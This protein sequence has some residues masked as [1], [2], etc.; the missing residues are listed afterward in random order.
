ME[1]TTKTTPFSASLFKILGTLEMLALAAVIVA[2]A[3]KYLQLPGGDEILMIGM[4]VLAMT[5]FLMAYKPPVP[6]NS[7]QERRGITHL[8]VDTILPK[9]TWTGCTIAVIGSLF[10]ILH[11]QGAG[12]MLM[13]GTSVLIVCILLSV[14]FIATGSDQTSGLM[15]ILY[16]A[17]PLCIFGIYVYMNLPPK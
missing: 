7:Q 13:V 1:P 10:G 9:V 6:T 14:Y 17:A 3:L 15:G 5:Y 8:F 4:S 11:L 12:Q 2:I 16:R